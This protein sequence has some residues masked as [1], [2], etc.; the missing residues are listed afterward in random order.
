MKWKRRRRW[1]SRTN[2]PGSRKKWFMLVMVIFSLFSLQTFIFVE[3]NLRDPL[4][5]IA[6]IR[7]KQ[8]ATEA[9]NSSITKNISQGTN[10]E[11]L[12]DWK[13]DHSGKIAGFM[14]NYAEHMKIASDTIKTVQNTLDGL[15]QIPDHIP[16]GEAFNS[17]ILASFGPEIPI[18][19]VPAGAVKVDLNT[20]QINAGINMLLVEVYIRIIA[21]VTIIIPFDTQ[22]EV[23][24]TEVPISY[25]LVVGDT[26]MY[27]VDNKG[28]PIGN[29]DPLPPNISL[30]DVQTQKNGVSS[31]NT[32]PDSGSTGTVGPGVSLKK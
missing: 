30:P 12:I 2:K 17:A 13:T 15:K 4:M 28:N 16:L 26:P 3:K 8:M 7:I 24:S 6:K 32:P 9:I 27:Y 10:F 20:R 29:S 18:K 5:N 25:L 11:K 19:F 23:V 31:F 1:K 21:E 22:P 14:L